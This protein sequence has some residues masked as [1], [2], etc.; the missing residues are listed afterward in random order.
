MLSK[1]LPKIRN[2]AVL[3]TDL[4]RHQEINSQL[5][6]VLEA[7]LL[8]FPNHKFSISRVLQTLKGEQ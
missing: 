6:S 4:E 2:E 5:I 7:L 1:Q 8:E 3:D